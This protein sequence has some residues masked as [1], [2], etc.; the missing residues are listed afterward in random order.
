MYRWANEMGWKSEPMRGRGGAIF[1]WFF[2]GKDLYLYSSAWMF[3]T[4]NQWYT[5]VE[6]VPK[7]DSY[8]LSWV[9]DGAK[10]YNYAT[11]LMDGTLL[12]R[13]PMSTSK[14]RGVYYKWEARFIPQPEYYRSHEV[15]EQLL[16]LSSPSDQALMEALSR[17]DRKDRG[18]FMFEWAVK[19]P[20]NGFA[21]EKNLYDELKARGF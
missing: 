18:L 7:G 8:E 3:N 9:W 16:S 2:V 13:S 11:V 10:E 5:R 20:L 15:Y 6:V 19:D 21:R 1:R 14:G 17:T 4:G 12:G